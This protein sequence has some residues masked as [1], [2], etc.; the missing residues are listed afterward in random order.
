MADALLSGVLP[1]IYSFGDRAKRQLK[2]LLSNPS[3]VVQQAS[4]Q[5][6]DNQKQIADLH[7]QAFGDSRNPLKITNRQAFNE[8]ADKATN[9]MMDMNAGV[10][11]PKG[12]NW[13][14]NSVE[15]GL[16]DL[17]SPAYS[18]TSPQQMIEFAESRLK[19]PEIN[20]QGKE[21]L[22]QAIQRNKN[23]LSINN[24]IDK[25]LTNYVKKEMGTP[26][27]PVRK[28]A[29]QG[30]LHSPME[31]GRYRVPENVKQA[32]FN[33][34]FPIEGMG[35]SDL[36]KA[37]EH[38]S[39]ASI[40]PYEVGFL[41]NAQN[42]PKRLPKVDQIFEQNPWLS[43]LNPEEVVYE[44][45]YPFGSLRFDHIM[46]VLKEDV[47]SGRLRPESLKNVSMEQAVRRTH[48]YDQELAK[49]MEDARAKKLEDMTVHK[50]YP[51][52]YKWVQLDK[53][54]QF[55][56]ESQ[57]MGHSVRGYEPPKGHPD[58]VEGSGEEGS[59]SYGHG[60]WEGIK[61]GKAKVYSLVDPKGNPHTTVET[62]TKGALT[63]ENFGVNDT[64]IVEG[65]GDYGERGYKTTD[66]QF[67]ESYADAVNHEKSIK[68]P[69]EA[70][71]K[72]PSE[73]TQI[74]GKGNRAPNEQYL[75][76]VQDFVKSG[77]WS[78]VGDIHNTGLHDTAM[79]GAQDIGK[80]SGF[81]LPR[82]MAKED[83]ETVMPLIH[84]YNNLKQMH[85]EKAPMPEEL[86]SYL[87]NQEPPVEGMKKGGAVSISDNPDTMF[88]ELT[89]RKLA[90][91]GAVLSL[92]TNLPALPKTD[93]HSI[94]KLMAHISKEHKIP[95]QKLHD[96][97]VA[98]HHMTPDT[99]IK[100]K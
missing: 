46:D 64:R 69:T 37:W 7:N 94:D 99:W 9:S 15:K 20:E 52:G 28:L 96:D 4:G 84:K 89:D 11:K 90:K 14:T 83:Y 10:I 19:D 67:F 38:L 82:F 57:A 40:K 13:L 16:E 17:K 63:D 50:E 12:G 79:T 31:Q 59:L 95:P 66:N 72:Q 47:A 65:L 55:A 45:Q 30:I 91:G 85:G 74:K 93:Y 6:I 1:A 2:D 22:R 92:E 60:G 18:G 75:P 29:E 43:K 41:K 58:W 24:W 25:N 23:E 26:E 35:Q 81:N 76:F 78:D 98:K 5:L 39:D 44:T 77:N 73:I 21:I 71:L 27:D 68:K 62:R 87:P 3:G 97:F 53:P 48:E 42:D 54:G 80:A 49:K 36:A 86:K 88:M 33:A 51:E 34:G 56:S 61:S 32:R 100:R 70:E 8:L